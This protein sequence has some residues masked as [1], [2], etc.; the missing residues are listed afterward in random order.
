MQLGSGGG[1]GGG[2]VSEQA[3]V[4]VHLEPSDGH[5]SFPLSR[6]IMG[7]RVGQAG[8]LVLPGTLSG[9]LVKGQENFS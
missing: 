7:T 4:S 6:G 8:M 2:G 3:S 5:T 9:Q 1:D